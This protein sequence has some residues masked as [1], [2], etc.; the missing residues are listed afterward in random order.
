MHA[1]RSVLIATLFLLNVGF[2]A[3]PSP[4]VNSVLRGRVVNADGPVAGA[5]VRWQGAS[6]FT[7]TDT[8]G[9]FLLRG[10]QRRR[11]VAAAKSGYLIAAGSRQH[12][13]LRLQPIPE[14]DHDDYAWIDP[15]SD[16]SKPLQCANC[17]VQIHKEWSA[18]SHGNSARNLKFLHLFAGS[19]GKSPAAQTWNLQKEHPL[20][21][22]VCAACHAP[23]LTSPT[24]EYDIREARG[25]HAQ[26]V[27]CDYCHKIAEAPTDKL[28]TR[29]GR[30]GYRLLRPRDG[31]QL[32]FGPLD[33]A[34]RAGESF[35]YAPF[36]KESK[37]C[38]S[39]HE[40]VV[41]GVHVYG[42]YSEWL[43]SP[44][45][46]QG[47]QCQDCHMAPTGKMTNI[48]PGHG[49]VQRD[50]RT[51]ASH[52]FPGGTVDMLRQC[53]RVDVK[54]TRQGQEMLV[55]V[56]TLARDVG[57]RVPTGFIDRHLILV[58]DGGESAATQPKLSEGP[59]LPARAGPEFAGRP[60]WIYGKQHLSA[61]GRPT[62]FWL[63]ANE[64]L[65]TRLQPE[66]ADVRR[67]VFSNDA[68]A[69]RVRLLYRRF[70][71]DV[72]VPRGWTDNDLLIYE[73]AVA[74]NGGDGKAVGEQCTP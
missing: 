52:E 3:L 48:A 23:T 38:A 11:L 25:V 50:P 71:A 40:G 27:H 57:H 53:L 34:V 28:G 36:Y 4:S 43:D 10:P 41:F 46:R 1:K 22:G 30:D 62:P 66:S 31:A 26:G 9:R 32:F 33:D 17:H 49:G 37:Y 12:P 65:D 7:S 42:T 18:S 61:A 6:D 60:G 39:C 64:M 69:I 73:K 13:R 15:S 74:V 51:L 45:R 70:W 19:D 58:V 72:A 5:T 67:F 20:G 16:S 56:I 14:D 8:D 29:F 55:T 63:S 59:T 47:R 2:L 68:G 24:L 21:G 54:A 35:A 44:A